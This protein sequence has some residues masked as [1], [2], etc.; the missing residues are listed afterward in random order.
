MAELPENDRIAGPFIAAAGQTDFPGDFPLIDAPGDPAGT[1]VVFVRERA[2]VA[3]ELGVGDFTIAASTDGGFTLRLV[4]PALAG[5]RCYIVG[6]QRQARLRAHPAGGAIRT[7]TLEDDA[8]EAAARHQEA[9]R[10][11]GRSLQVPI[12]ETGPQLPAQAARDKGVAWFDGAAVGAYHVEPGQVLGAH[13]ETGVPVSIAPVFAVDSTPAQAPSRLAAMLMSF[14]ETLMFVRTAGYDAVGDGGGGLY[15]R[16]AGEPEHGGKFQS[17]DGAW[18]ELCEDKPNVLQFGAKPTD[19]PSDGDANAAAFQAAAFYRPGVDVFIPA[20]A[21]YCSGTGC[22]AAAG[23]SFRGA[24]RYA[25]I[26][27]P[28]ADLTTQD[29]AIFY[30]SARYTS[31]TAYGFIEDVG[32]DLL[33]QDCTAISLE[34]I[35]NFKVVRCRGVGGGSLETAAGALVRFGAPIDSGAYSNRAIDCD[36]LHLYA[37][38]VFA[39]GG[40]HNCVDGGEAIVC[41][42]GYDVNPGGIG[43]DT[44]R[45]SNVRTEG[46]NIGIDDGAV[47]GMYSFCRH[48]NNVLTDIRFNAASDHPLVEGGFT[49]VT[50]NSVLGL[51]DMSQGFS[52]RSDDMGWTEAEPSLSR[53]RRFAMKQ[54]FYGPGENLST[55]PLLS[56]DWALYLGGTGVIRRGFSLEF[57]NA[58]DTNTLIGLQ[59][60]GDTL[61]VSGYDRKNAGYG[62]VDIGGG[63]AVRPITDNGT[64]CGTAGRRWSEVFA[65]NATINTSDARL[66][67][68]VAE[69]TAAEKAVAQAL[70][71]LIRTFRWKEAVA[72]KGEAARIHVGVVAQQVIAAFEAQGLD[73][74]R[75]SMVCRDEWPA[76][77]E[78][79]SQPVY[80]EEPDAWEGGEP[81]LYAGGEMWID[82]EGRPQRRAEG[83]PVLDEAGQP[84]V[85]EAG[86]PKLDLRGRPIMRRVEKE[87]ARLLRPAAPAGE[88]YSIRYEEMLAFII[89]A[90][91]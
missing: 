51:G 34:G 78:V 35:N 53:V 16:A 19:D 62:P 80:D 86:E 8:R 83:E 65:G 88:R 50:P 45:I 31:T 28:T 4:V 54:A 56:G 73:P 23:V 84:R 12:G 72:E 1:C 52:I 61:V 55:A 77:P 5:D 37:V 49:A 69:L 3:T 39:E 71:G 89:G 47:Q 13:P 43:V 18:W 68:D 81:V 38:V 74:F 25:T 32:F 9:A 91:E 67:Q 7:P 46:C 41:Q 66:K 76:E 87:P 36:G 33:G 63:S 27:K 2:G 30:S 42:K 24:G 57:V 70:K 10:D 60:A 14:A 15:K 64:S 44:P 26:I 29:D 22:L 90:M 40:N 79:W 82:A 6:R 75:Y 17:A 85:R 11:L 20:G 21:F 48:E 59:T 58:D